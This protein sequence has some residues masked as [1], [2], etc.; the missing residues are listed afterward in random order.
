MGKF[1]SPYKEAGIT[2]NDI[3]G[4]ATK[5]KAKGFPNDQ[6]KNHEE[7][8]AFAVKHNVFGTEAYK[9]KKEMDGRKVNLIPDIKPPKQ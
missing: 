9:L 7:Y 3:L 1:S 6:F 4:T 5:I 8:F 2:A